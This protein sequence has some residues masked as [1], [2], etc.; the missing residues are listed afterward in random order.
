MSLRL[1]LVF[2]CAALMLVFAVSA[3]ACPDRCSAPGH[4][5]HFAAE[6]EASAETETVDTEEDDSEWDVNEP[7]GESFDITFTTDEGTWMSLD[8]SPDGETIVFDLVGD[9]YTI[10]VGGGQATRLTSGMAWDYQP[11]YSPDG[12]EILFTSDRA[13]GN[14]LWTMNADG[15]DMEAFSDTGEKDTNCGAWS[16]DGEWIASKRRLT[17]GSSIGATELWMFHR[18][19][20]DG[21]QV[22][23]K[24]DIPEVSEPVF[25]PDGRFLYFSARPRRFT[26]DQNPY[27]GIYQVRKFDRQTGKFARVTNRFGGAGRPTISPDGKTLTFIS[28]DELDVVLVARALGRRQDPARGSGERRDD[29]DLILGGRGI[30][31]PARSAFR[32]RC[33]Q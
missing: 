1:P 9:I 15:T 8:V 25:H 19:G 5:G 4:P 33:E 30:E 24:D 10:P 18:L 2:L 28:R 26:Y 6:D 16:P 11:R 17:D 31:G 13:G 23:K 7:P 21:I 22:T 27:Q 20:G 29:R 12:T 32:S 3:G 14:N